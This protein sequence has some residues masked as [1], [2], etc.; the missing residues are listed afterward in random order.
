MRCADG[1]FFLMSQL[2]FNDARTKACFVERG[3]TIAPKPGLPLH[4]A[5]PERQ[6]EVVDADARGLSQQSFHQSKR[7]WAA[8]LKDLGCQ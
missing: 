3:K 6:T 5:L 7:V 1:R 2:S 8:G 4:D